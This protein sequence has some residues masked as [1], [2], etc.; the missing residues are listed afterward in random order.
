MES[1]S[2]FLKTLTS[3]S[4]VPEQTQ[5]GKYKDALSIFITQL[6]SNYESKEFGKKIKEQRN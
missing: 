5:D 2:F 1:K 6:F 4:K 3:F